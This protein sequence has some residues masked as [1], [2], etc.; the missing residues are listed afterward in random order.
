MAL[1]NIADLETQ[2]AQRSNQQNQPQQAQANPTQY[3]QQA[4]QMPQGNTIQ[5]TYSPRVAEI[6]PL[7]NPQLVAQQQQAEIAGKMQGQP[8]L[9][10]ATEQA[11]NTVVSQQKVAEEN[12]TL[13]AFTN[14]LRE[15]SKDYGKAYVNGY[16]GNS[17]NAFWGKLASNGMIPANGHEVGQKGYGAFEALQSSMIPQLNSIYS[18]SFGGQEPS[19]RI[20]ASL[21]ELGRKEVPALDKTIP[22][23]E[24]QVQSSLQRF[25]TVMTGALNYLKDNYSSQQLLQA[26]KN[27]PKVLDQYAAN[28]MKN[29]QAYQLSPEVSQGLQDRYNKVIQP[30]EA[31]KQGKVVYDV[32]KEGNKTYVIPNG[33]AKD[34][35]KE[36][37]L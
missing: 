1:I 30:L 37:G 6:N 11:K 8:Q 14:G 28:A 35:E 3:A 9:D 27:N 7:L 19:T 10:A 31:A 29:G 15:L 32:P 12:A 20:M 34:F 23:N 18:T 25:G 5:P 33:M 4:S 22:V 16:A 26:Y 17:V 2:V 21:L 13:D 24:G 36:K